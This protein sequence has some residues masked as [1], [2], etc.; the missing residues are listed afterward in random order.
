MRPPKTHETIGKLEGLGEVGSFHE[1]QDGDKQRRDERLGLRSQHQLRVGDDLWI[2]S[3]SG[4]IR[5]AHGIVARRQITQDF[6]DSN[7]FASHPES[8]R[9]L[10]RATLADGRSI[11]R[12]QVTPPNGESYG[13][14]IDTTTWLIDEETYT[15][16]DATMS[17]ILDDYHVVD[18]MLLPYKEVDSGGDAH[19]ALTST[20]QSVVVN[21]P[22]PAGM[23]APL[24]PM[25]MNLDA[26]VTVP[27]E[28]YIGLPFVVVKMAGHAYHFLVDSGSQ[29]NVV[30]PRLATELGLRPQGQIVIEGATRVRS[31]G[32]VELP[33]VEIGALTLNGQVATVLDLS[34]IPSGK[35]PLD[36]VLG[37]P[38]FGAA[39]LRFDPDRGLL[40][41]AKPGSLPVV[42][43]KLDVDGDREL[44]EI[45][46]KVNRDAT[47]R[48]IVDTGSTAEL[49]LYDGFIKSHPGLVSFVGNSM[50]QNRGAGG[51]TSAVGTFV[52]DLQIGS[53]H[54]YNRRADVILSTTGAFADR[55]DGGNV[56][57]GVLRN[58]IAT[59]DVV[60]HALYLQRAR[61]FDDGRLRDRMEK[62]DLIQPVHNP[63][64]DL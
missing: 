61:N 28:T 21:K 2:Q 35:V 40:T 8:V 38:L 10:E 47:T 44:V 20:V 6:I 41:I 19:S 31:L 37:G 49:L 26:P 24:M 60:N 7:G 5:Q 45:S 64:T 33:Q 63:V 25:G 59:F 27:V 55:L 4:Q 56:G 17:V 22:I 11:Y 14:G 48:V 13:V 50:V 36:G 54:L 52:D 43:E 53:F 32:S 18:G 57:S 23:F 46:A 51:S 9:F 16:N 34:R 1:W 12:L 58:F 30:D 39:E 29:G 42:G 15:E 62:L 3:A